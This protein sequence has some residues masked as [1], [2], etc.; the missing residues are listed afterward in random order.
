MI[1]IYLINTTMDEQLLRKGRPGLRKGEKK[2]NLSSR[3]G[4]R[5]SQ[6]DFNLGW[7]FVFLK[8]MLTLG[9]GFSGALR[10]DQEENEM[11]RRHVQTLICTCG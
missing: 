5:W 8:F 10:T 1:F 6:Q 7:L 3:K 2:R 4:A 9:E 11:G